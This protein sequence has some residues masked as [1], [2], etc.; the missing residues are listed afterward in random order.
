MKTRYLENGLAYVGA[1]V[2]LMGVLA[3]ANSAFAAEP[4]NTDRAVVAESDA[5][6]EAIN[7]AKKAIRES[8]DAA[9]EALEIE[10]NFDLENQL[11]DISSTL[12][13]A[14]K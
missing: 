2:V 7:G 8:A 13:A 3:A 14:N 11:S 12:I 5:A 4:E 6:V 1:L 9:A 10:N